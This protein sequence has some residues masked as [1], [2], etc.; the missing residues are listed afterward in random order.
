MSEF[1]APPI[2]GDRRRRMAAEATLQTESVGQGLSADGQRGPRPGFVRKPFGSQRQKLQY[3]NREG[4]HRHWFN[5]EPGRIEAAAEAGY[6][7]V[8][9]ERKGGNV[10]TVV[11]TA[12]GG[13]A[14][15]AFLMEIPE[16]WYREDM[17]ANEAEYASRMQE[18]RQGEHAKPQ[19]RDG[20]LRYAGSTRGDISIR[21][22]DRR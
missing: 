19:G 3:P 22:S 7:H 13:G 20:Q 16:E 11:G 10:Q 15:I 17:A 2:G 1:T 4:Y 6:E 18:I 8:R 9:D 5:D 14:L 12:R 21:E